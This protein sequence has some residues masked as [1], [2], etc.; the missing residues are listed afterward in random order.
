MS[1]SR[2]VANGRTKVLRELRKRRGWLRTSE[3][4][5]AGIHGRWLTELVRSGEIE[6]VRKGL[7]RLTTTPVTAD[8]TFTTVCRAVPQGVI[9]LLSALAYHQLTTSNP[10]EI[11]VALPKGEWL[12]RLS[13][14]PVRY[15]RFSARMM[16]IGVEQRRTRRGAFRIFDREKT[17]CDAFRHWDVVGRDVALEAL[18]TYLRGRPRRN[19]DRLLQ[20]ARTCRV[21]RRVRPYLEALL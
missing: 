17:I 3:A 5:A 13:Y 2:D 4:A 14:P 10:S 18:R 19:V 20:L 8:E 12:P 15:F 11:N 6:R 1:A 9:C 7:Y 21:E 16:T